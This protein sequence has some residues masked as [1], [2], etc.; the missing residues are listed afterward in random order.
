M[1]LDGEPVRDFNEGG[2]EE[3]PIYGKT[4]LP[5]KFKIGIAYPGD[6]CVDV[7]TQDVGAV[8]VLAEGKLSGFN[9]LV[10]GGQGMTHRKAETFP[11]LA[12]PLAF[13]APEELVDLIEHIVCVQRDHGD[14]TDRRHARLKYLIHDRGLDWFR[15]EVERRRGRALEPPVSIPP[16]TL[17]LHLGWRRQAAGEWSLGL[18]VENGRIRDENG[19]RL[20][21]G[22]RA[23]LKRLGTPV[24]LTPHQDLLLTGLSDA[25]RRVVEAMLDEHGIPRAGD[26]ST[27]RLHSMACPALPTCGLALSEAERALPSVL[28]ELEVELARLGLARE[29]LTV[30]MTGCPNGCARPYVADLAFVGRS[31]DRFLILVG[32]RSDGTR[33]NQAYQDLVPGNA[34]VSTVVPLLTF[35]KQSR[36]AEESFGDFCNRVGVDGLHAFADAIGGVTVH[37]Q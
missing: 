2:G 36:K 21:T 20:R 1:W 31:L 7:F 22:L 23:I 6:N 25:Q 26:L 33:L 5:R 4:Y 14:R 10:G 19:V 32:G 3:E 29:R 8:A 12:D 30:R 11:R 27:V 9:V 17:E 15:R 13:V 16:F 18:P 24:T 37:D 28:A 35:Y 34:L